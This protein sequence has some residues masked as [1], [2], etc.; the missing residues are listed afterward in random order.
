MLGLIQMMN[1]VLFLS[2][3]RHA[4]NILVTYSR[5]SAECY[6]RIFSP[7]EV[8]TMQNYARPVNLIMKGVNQ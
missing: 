8:T 5:K 1:T 2:K 6:N 7:T 4:F 3:I